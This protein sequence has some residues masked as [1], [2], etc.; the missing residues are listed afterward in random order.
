MYITLNVRVIIIELSNI[1]KCT[2]L[3]CRIWHLFYTGFL[4]GII[5]PTQVLPDVRVQQHSNILHTM[6]LQSS[7]IEL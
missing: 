6:T 1:T 7:D 5:R 4:F 3:G 2:T